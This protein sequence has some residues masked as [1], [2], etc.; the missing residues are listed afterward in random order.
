MTTKKKTDFVETF[1]HQS[2]TFLFIYFYFFANVD[3]RRKNG[4]VSKLCFYAL[5]RKWFRFKLEATEKAISSFGK[6][7]KI[8]VLN[9]SRHVLLC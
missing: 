8:M 6:Y 4:L 3:W 7:S 2:T 9:T 1:L 5:K